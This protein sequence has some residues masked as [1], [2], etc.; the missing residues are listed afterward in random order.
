MNDVPSIET[1]WLALIEREP[2]AKCAMVGAIGKLDADIAHQP[3][4]QA[5]QPGRPQS[6]QLVSPREVP[7]RGLGSDAGRAA[8]LHAIAHIEFNA[9]NLALDA[10]LR[11]ADMPAQ[12]YE[13]WL[14]VAKDEA[15]H[16]TMLA[17]RLAT[18]GHRYGDV[19]A[20][21]GL[22]EA[23]EK[24]A[25]DVLARMALVPRV[26]EA[27]GLDVTPGMIHRLTEMRDAQTVAILR[28]ILD[29]EVRHVAIGTYWF[30]WLCAQR[31][32][33]PDA[34]FR[35]LLAESDTRIRPPLN[36]PARQAAGFSRNELPPEL[37]AGL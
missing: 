17:E 19:P 3:R 34:T 18:F 4:P 26:L 36:W 7:V 21:N 20:H 12:Y 2:E 28:V 27:R 25:Y 6:L 13:D 16:F 32:L 33:E 1:L 14:S 23:A 9:I 37:L 35:K 24:T 31:S 22:W 8:L 30:R 10:C 5:W 11:F 29:E 15:R